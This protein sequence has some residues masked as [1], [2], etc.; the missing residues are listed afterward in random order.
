MVPSLL[1]AETV[2]LRL[3]CRLQPGLCGRGPPV[4][5]AYGSVLLP[6]VLSSLGLRQLP[7]AGRE[8]ILQQVSPRGHQQ[9]P[10]LVPGCGHTAASPLCSVFCSCSPSWAQLKQGAAARKI[11]RTNWPA[12]RL[13][14]SS[15]SYSCICR[16]R[17]LSSPQSRA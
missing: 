3:H 10:A 2:Q 8:V 15:D 17:D 5:G 14:P 16:E 4:F 11:L 13:T 6:G 7:P 9:P 12:T 1:A